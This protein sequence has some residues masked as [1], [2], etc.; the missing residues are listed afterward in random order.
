MSDKPTTDD[1][2]RIDTYRSGKNW[3]VRVTDLRTGRVLH[4]DGLGETA[5]QATLRDLCL[6]LTRPS[7]LAR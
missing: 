4:G 3:T 5:L 6:K 7:A 2:L 1:D